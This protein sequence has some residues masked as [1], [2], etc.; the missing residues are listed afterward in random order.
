MP[1]CIHR[2]Q[3]DSAIATAT[4]LTTL[5]THR[6][7]WSGLSPP[8]VAVQKS[9]SL[10]DAVSWLSIVVSTVVLAVSETIC[11]GYARVHPLLK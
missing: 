10:T 6:P 9:P 5:T 11:L 8:H 3:H 7:G 2:V 4:G 1:G